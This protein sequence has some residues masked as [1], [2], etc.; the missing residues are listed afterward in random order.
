VAEPL[1]Q[2]GAPDICVAP[3][4]TEASLVALI[5]AP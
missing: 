2:A 3:E 1:V 5:P 4:P